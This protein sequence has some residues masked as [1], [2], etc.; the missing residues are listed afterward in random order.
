[1]NT[2]IDIGI[3]LTN[4]QFYKEHE[5]IINRALDHGVETYDSHRNQHT[6][7]QRVCGNCTRISRKFYF[8]QPEFI[9]T[10]PNL[11]MDKVLMSSEN[12]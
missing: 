11:L 7:K 2:Y 5:E 8:Q 9:P 10:M 4:K 6:W 3:N 1:M 12:Y